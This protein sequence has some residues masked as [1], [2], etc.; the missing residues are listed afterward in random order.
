[1]HGWRALHLG[2][3][4]KSESLRWTE[5]LLYL[6]TND[7]MIQF[8]LEK[9]MINWLY[10]IAWGRAGA[11]WSG[12]GLDWMDGYEYEDWY[13]YELMILGE[14]NFFFFFKYKLECNIFICIPTPVWNL[15]G[16][17]VLVFP[18]FGFLFLATMRIYVWHMVYSWLSA[19]I[20]IFV[21]WILGEWKVKECLY[22]YMGV[23]MDYEGEG[24][25]GAWYSLEIDIMCLW[26][27]VRGW[28]NDIKREERGEGYIVLYC[29]VLYYIFEIFGER[30]RGMDG[31][32]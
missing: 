4:D 19:L 20:R 27:M 5:W 16:L 3:D 31:Y 15:C 10:W 1:M 22:M 11:N 8:C 14:S 6:C 2:L 23:R 21:Q 9:K 28:T 17:V 18:K 25:R 24:G 32:T 13:G 12:E 30:E 26:R 7:I 29:I